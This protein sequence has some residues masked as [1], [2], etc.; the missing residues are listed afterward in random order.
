MK[1]NGITRLRRLAIVLVALLPA[2]AGAQNATGVWRTEQTD[3]GHIEVEIKP[4]GA[5]LCG[6][7]VQAINLQGEAAKTHPY[8]GRKMIWDMQPDGAGQWA[9][10]K[11][12]DPRKDKAFKSK[13]H[14]SGRNLTVKGCFLAIC[15]SQ[16][17]RPV[18]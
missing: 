11:I 18:D 8:L 15:Q 1:G 3:E 9:D 6:T 10:G 12:W 4:C 7:I 17:W 5:A 2:V 13:M 14:R 16:T